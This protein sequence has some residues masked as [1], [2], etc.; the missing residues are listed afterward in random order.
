MRRP[1]GWVQ[2][3]F[4]PGCARGLAESVIVLMIEKGEAVEHLGAIL[5]VEGIDMVQFG[6]ADYA[7][8]MGWSRGEDADAIRETE[9]L[10][11]SSA[12][13]RG[14]QPRAEIADARGAE[15]YTEHGVRHFCVGHDVGILY[16]WWTVQGGLMREIL[17][18]VP[19]DAA[20]GRGPDVKHP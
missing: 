5:A 4:A 3:V 19:R 10:V 14:I 12:L 15:W 20:S 9:R 18:A 6:P 16:N 7:L 8:S 17:A 11:I 2:S 1:A 13:E